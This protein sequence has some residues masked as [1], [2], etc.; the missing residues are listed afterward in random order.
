[1]F[2]KKSPSETVNIYV[3]IRDQ[4]FQEII[5]DMADIMY[6]SEIKLL[7]EYSKCHALNTAIL[8]GAVAQRLGFDDTGVG[9]VIL[10]G[11]L[12]DIGKTRVED[13]GTSRT[14]YLHTTEGYNIIKNEM[15]LSEQIA[16]VA[17]EHHENNDG[18]GY[19]QGLSGDWIDLDSQIINVCNTFDNITFNK[20]HYKVKN[21][22]DALRAILE[23]GS[24]KFSPKILYTMVNM[25]SYNDTV[26]FEDMID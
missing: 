17:L 3:D 22:K 14:M 15:G 4:I 6:C 16:K 11:L 19:P 21:T 18:S 20:T 23:Y 10:A 7:G 2:S 12:H 1:M 8:S 5:T 9:E 24:K 25:F 26:N 13:D